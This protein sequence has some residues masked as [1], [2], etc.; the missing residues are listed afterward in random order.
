MIKV[1][2]LSFSYLKDKPVLEDVSFDIKEGECVILLGPNGV[3]KST[4]INLLTGVNKIKKGD[5]IFN[6]KSI[7]DITHKEKANYIAYVPQLIEGNDLTVRDTVLLGRLPYY[8]IYPNKI[9][10]ALTDKYIEEFKLDSIK[11]NATNR[12]SGGERQKCNIAR[13]FIQDSKLIILD[14]PTNN[15]DIA[16]RMEVLNLIKSERNKNKKSFIISMHDINEALEI[17]DKFVMLK[18]KHIYKIL[19][20]EELKEED[21]YNVYNVKNKIIDINGRRHIIYEN[22]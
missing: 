12:I 17:G 2:N 1:N 9:D 10:Y 20:K 8:K 21:I 18:D 4:L 16:S 5:I 15:L 22:D 19:T 3:G 7:K 14:E 13:G 6:D 11:D